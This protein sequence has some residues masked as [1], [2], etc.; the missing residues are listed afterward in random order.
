MVDTRDIHQA[1]LLER[2]AELEAQLLERDNE[3]DNL[4]AE[5]GDY[6]NNPR[7][8]EEKGKAIIQRW[9]KN[10]ATLEAQL[11]TARGIGNDLANTQHALI[12]SRDRIA[13]LEAENQRMSRE[14]EC[15]H[16]Q[17]E[18]M[19]Q[20]E[21]GRHRQIREWAEKE[22]ELRSKVENLKAG[23]KIWR[24]HGSAILLPDDDTSLVGVAMTRRQAREIVESHN[25]GLVTE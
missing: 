5:V 14:Q 4:A 17:I 21:R 11:N 24:V 7:S 8:P 2:I 9:T 18:T 23:R 13:A 22:A 15:L 20:V 16:Q 1:P 19:E 3:N 10:I 25:R 6:I 12:E